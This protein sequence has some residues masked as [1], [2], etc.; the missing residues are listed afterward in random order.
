MKYPPILLFAYNRP[1]HFKKTIVSLGKNKF[2]KKHDLLIFIDGPKNKIDLKKNLQIF[3]LIKNNKKF[4]T[5][6]IFKDKK[7]KG[8]KKSII[9]G[10]NYAFKKNESIIVLEDDIVTNK[11]FLDYM[12]KSLDFYKNNPSIGT[13]SAYSYINLD[14]NIKDNVYLSQRHSSWGWGTWKTNWVNM[15]WS[16]NWIRNHL[17]KKN[18]RIKFNKSGEDMYHMLNLQSQ[19]KIDSWAI[20]YN[21]NCFLENKYCLCPKKS[22]IFNIGMD[23][24]G[25]HCKKNDEVF[26]NYNSNFSIAKFHNVKIDDKILKKIQNS[27]HTPISKRLI[28][29]ISKIF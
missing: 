1:E 23:G 24:S 3:N 27:F 16:N 5:I 9:N 28:N 12:T 22:L 17:Y 11:Y 4:K 2:A 7:N 26:S 6:K 25:I 10:V 8:L 20:I 18:F 13:V 19:K 15:K 21:L 14:K 29:K